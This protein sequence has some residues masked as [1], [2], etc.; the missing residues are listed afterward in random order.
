VNLF[1]VTASESNSKEFIVERS[2]DGTHFN[3]IGRVDAAGFS[4]NLH[5]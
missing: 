2:G 4:N 1:W 3:A 5:K